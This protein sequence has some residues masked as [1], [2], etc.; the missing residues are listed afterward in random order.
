MIGQVSVLCP[1]VVSGE[2]QAGDRVRSAA[3]VA[4]HPCGARS[5]GPIQSSSIQS[6]SESRGAQ[7]LWE[8]PLSWKEGLAGCGGVSWDGQ[9]VLL[10]SNIPWRISGAVKRRGRRDQGRGYVQCVPSRDQSWYSVDFPRLPVMRAPHAPKAGA[11]TW[12][13]RAFVGSKTCSIRIQCHAGRCP[14][15]S[16]TRYL[17]DVGL[18]YGSQAKPHCWLLGKTQL[19]TWR[20]CREAR[21]RKFDAVR[22]PRW[23]AASRCH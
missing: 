20:G 8:P 21:W 15:K 10:V 22:G 11:G 1:A 9:R 7:G 6:S 2:E 18:T 12:E 16:C 3:P 14:T 17:I 5:W 4:L 19:R 23:G 13:N